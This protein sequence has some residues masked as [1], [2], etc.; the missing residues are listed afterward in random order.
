MSLTVL[1]SKVTY[2]E[3]SSI[4]LNKLLNKNSFDVRLGEEET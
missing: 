1:V 2:A 4:L 3:I